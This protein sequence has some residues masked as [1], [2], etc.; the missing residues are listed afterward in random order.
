MG[1]VNAS[2]KRRLVNHEINEDDQNHIRH[3]VTN[4]LVRHKNRSKISKEET[5]ALNDL[6]KDDTIVILPADKGRRTVVMNKADYIEKA[7][8]LLNDT[9]TYTKLDSDPT[10]TTTTRINNQLKTL[11][12]KKKL[13]ITTYNHLRS[14]DATI[15]KFY[16]LPKIHK[17]DIPLRPIVSLPGS[18]TYNLAKHLA[19]ILKPLTESSAHAVNNVNSFLSCTKNLNRMR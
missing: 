1:N 15:A 5:R 19:S 14:S 17:P 13:N 4:G 3:E 2:V 12:D 8:T 10:K 18:P 7:N 6:K 11:K 9:N 16:G